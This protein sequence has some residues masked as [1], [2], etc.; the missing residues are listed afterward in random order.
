MD[1]RFL[2][3]TGLRVSE[4]ALGVQT[5]GWCTEEAEAFAILDRFVAAGGNFL[6]VAD[7]YNKGQ[8][9]AMLGKWLASRKGRSKLVLATKVYFPVGEGPNDTGL[10]RKHILDS[11]HESLRRL[12]TDYI[13]LYQV[14]CWD[15][16]TPLEETLDTLDTLVRAG[17]VRY[18]G[19]SNFTAS[20]L[21]KAIYLC[22]LHG[23]EEPVSTQMEYSLLVRTVEWEVLPSCRAEGV[24]FLPWSP[25]AGGWLTGKYRRDRAPA[26][27]SR[28]G[29]R[30]RWEDLPE[31]RASERTWR[32]IEAL[33]EVAAQRG[34]TPAQVA[35]NWLLRQPGVVAP[36][37][38]A[39]TVAQLEE[40][41]GSVGWQLEPAEV[42]RLSQASAI[43]LPYP[44]DF[45]ARYAR[46]RE[47]AV[48]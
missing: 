48:G 37:F 19:V 20:Q 14:H 18:V 21:V 27:D 44:Y 45:I 46:K 36:I 3:K 26:P 47:G 39:R 41:L 30:D 10:S 2:G 7:S 8:S 6:D 42:E 38:G 34:K 33:V 25:L 12:Q 16:A 13:D 31:Q 5:F 40:N 17:K 4:V 11:L 22:R 43:P 35:I 23:W 1:Y 15:G 28:A 9:E 32:I 24:G 29:R